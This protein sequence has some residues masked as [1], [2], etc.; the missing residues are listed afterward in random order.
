MVRDAIRGR[1][2]QKACPCPRLFNAN[3][4]G[5]SKAAGMEANQT[6]RETAFETALLIK[7]T[8]LRGVSDLAPDRNTCCPYSG[9]SKCGEKSV[10]A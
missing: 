10:T 5:V 6:F 7:P 4:F 9:N 2:A 1:W 8:A 3:P